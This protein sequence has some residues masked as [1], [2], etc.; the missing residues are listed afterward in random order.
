MLEGGKISSGQAVFLNITMI[1]ATAMLA[2]PA[3][4]A[5]HARQDAWLSM[6][7]ATL[8]AL[9]IAWVTASLGTLFPGKTLVEYTED[10]LGKWPGKLLGLLYL[11]WF[12]HICSIMIREYGNFLIDVF[13][14]ETP[15]IVIN[16][17]GAALA[18][19]TVKNGLEVLARV[20]QI[21]LPII[22][23]SVILIFLLALPEMKLERFLPVFEA[24]TVKIFKGAIVPWGWMGEIITFAML[25]PF[26]AQPGQ[27][28]HTAVITIPLVGLF[29]TLLAVASVAVFGPVFSNMNFPVLNAARV[30]NIANFIDRPEPIIMAIWIIGGLLKISIFYYVSVLGFAQWLNLKDYRPLVLPV[31]V[32]LIALSIAVAENMLELTHFLGNVSPYE[33]L[34]FELVIPLTLLLIALVRRQ[35]GNR[36]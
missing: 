31:G 26:L 33:L 28:R 17:L 2:V 8:L 1:I 35:G 14:P 16:I 7:L 27:T 5:V 32:I 34:T 12:I 30:I 20:N 19:Y 25:I 29:F 10:I 11:L 15:L 24:E 3:I 23:I 6:L 21:F 36:Q 4:A 18:A 13:M 22:L 9:P